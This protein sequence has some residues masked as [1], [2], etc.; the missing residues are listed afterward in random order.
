MQ[1]TAG[2]SNVPVIWI[3]E[4]ENKNKAYLVKHSMLVI[5]NY[6]LEMC[7]SVFSKH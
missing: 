6:V 3:S 4:R 7:S 2:R 5:S 1:G